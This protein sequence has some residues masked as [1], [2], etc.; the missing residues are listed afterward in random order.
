MGT[1]D[2]PGPEATARPT[3]ANHGV[4]VEV[5][6]LGEEGLH[7]QGEEVQALDEQPEV[8]GH[9]AVVEENHYGLALHLPRGPE[10]EDDVS[11]HPPPRRALRTS[12]GGQGEFRGPF[13]SGLLRFTPHGWETLNIPGCEKFKV[14]HDSE[15][16]LP[17]E[18][19]LPMS[20]KDGVGVSIEPPPQAPS[21]HLPAPSQVPQ[22]R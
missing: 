10:R 14:A 18:T 2:I 20:A 19:T 7:Q 3:P 15:S 12:P 9:D 8:V 5:S 16:K 1:E 17:T 21:P 4:P 22:A 6:P 11:P 13:S